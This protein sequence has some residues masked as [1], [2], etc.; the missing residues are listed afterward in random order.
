MNILCT[1]CGKKGNCSHYTTHQVISFFIAITLSIP[2]DKKNTHIHTHTWTHEWIHLE[3][4][5]E[6]RMKSFSYFE[7]VK[8]FFFCRNQGKVEVKIFCAANDVCTSFSE[9]ML[10]LLRV[11]VWRWM[12]AFLG[13]LLKFKINCLY[14]HAGVYIRHKSLKE[15]RR[16]NCDEFV[17]GLT[18][19]GFVKYSFNEPTGKIELVCAA[20]F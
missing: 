9:I 6:R 20:L 18:F 19:Y 5:S 17:V 11:Y 3:S 2:S 4:A 16:S 1:V 10:E 12:E 14:Q 15:K 8:F 13:T 7:Q